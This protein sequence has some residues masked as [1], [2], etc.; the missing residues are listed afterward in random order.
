MSE[1]RLKIIEEKRRKQPISEIKRKWEKAKGRHS[2]QYWTA[3]WLDFAVP[4]HTTRW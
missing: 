4:I 2:N 3:E 1:E